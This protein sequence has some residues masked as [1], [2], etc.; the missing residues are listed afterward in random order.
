MLG[1]ACPAP[2]NPAT[3]NTVRSN[4]SFDRGRVVTNIT[5]DMAE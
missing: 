1:A 2:K 5:L 3:L 4:K